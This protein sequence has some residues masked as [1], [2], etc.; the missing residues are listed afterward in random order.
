MCANARVVRNTWVLPDGTPRS[1]EGIDF[2]VVCP[3]PTLPLCTVSPVCV[4]ASGWKVYIVGTE[5]FRIQG[6]YTFSCP[7]EIFLGY[8]CSRDVA[9]MTA[10]IP[11]KS[12]HDL[13]GLTRVFP[14]YLND[15]FDPVDPL[16]ALVP[17]S[18]WEWFAEALNPSNGSLEFAIFVSHVRKGAKCM[19]TTWC[20]G[21]P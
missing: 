18:A 8:A 16:R 21:V 12:R 5:S 13:Q 17:P 14:C 1:S 6:V 11:W 2:L 10:T 19:F 7:I 4:E 20:G 15:P 9:G 3:L